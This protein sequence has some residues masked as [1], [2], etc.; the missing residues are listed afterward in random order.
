M[1]ATRASDLFEEIWGF[2]VW[3]GSYGFRH[4]YLSYK[5]RFNIEDGVYNLLDFFHMAETRNGAMA[6]PNLTATFG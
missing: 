2:F 1:W 3:F 5:Y 6:I 4:C